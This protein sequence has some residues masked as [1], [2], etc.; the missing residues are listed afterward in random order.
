MNHD[1]SPVMTLWKP[2]ERMNERPVMRKE[3]HVIKWL[4][5]SFDSC[6]VH[7]VKLGGEH[8]EKLTAAEELLALAD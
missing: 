7:G 2:G 1:S 3:L 4:F 5:L 8:S 6:P